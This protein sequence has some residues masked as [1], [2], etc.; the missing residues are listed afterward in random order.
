[1]AEAATFKQYLL[2]LGKGFD[3]I[4]LHDVEKARPKS[5][6]ILVR[7]KAVSLNWRDC[8]LAKG[9]YPFPTPETVVPGSDGAG[10]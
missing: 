9:I 1:M 2:Q 6:Q 7:I 4:T 8:A 3:G 10:M 5:G